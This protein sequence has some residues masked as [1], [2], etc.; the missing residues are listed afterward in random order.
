MRYSAIIAIIILIAS[1]KQI[2]QMK[3][4]SNCD[5]RLDRVDNIHLANVKM[6]DMQSAVQ[7][8]FKELTA[9]SS[10]F[11]TNQLNVDFDTYIEAKNSNDVHAAMNQFDWIVQ[12]NKKDIISGT[13]EENINIPPGE[14]RM[15]KIPIH[16]NLNE[17]FDS[18]QDILD[19]ALSIAGKN[20]LPSNMA[21]KI[22]PSVSVGKRKI[23]Y[24]GYIT[25]DENY[26][27]KE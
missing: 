17:V 2:K 19:F 3:S 10:A 1:C 14:T 12:L 25:V 18:K 23:K 16:Q 11:L 21:I 20:E 26:S 24:P 22:K 4:F 7:F 27:S 13:F 6:D 9:I 15:V 8:S 5:F